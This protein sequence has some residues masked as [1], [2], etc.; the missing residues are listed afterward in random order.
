[1][2]VDGNRQ[3]EWPDAQGLRLAALID[4]PAAPQGYLLR[5]AVDGQKRPK[6]KLPKRL[7]QLRRE[8]VIDGQEIFCTARRHESVSPRNG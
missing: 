3:P 5:G 4:Q 1:F 6:I 8:G 2:R 7:E